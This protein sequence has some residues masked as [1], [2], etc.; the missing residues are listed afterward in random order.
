VQHHL[1]R[2]NASYKYDPVFALGFVSVFDQLMEGYPSEQDKA[3]IFQ[4][5]I[6][7][8]QEEPEKYRKDASQLEAWTSE[9][10]PEKLVAFQDTDGPVESLLKPN[11]RRGR[12]QTASSTT[13]AFSRLAF[14]GLWSWL[15]R[16]T[17]QHWRSY[18]LP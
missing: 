10:S 2:Y 6:Q 3:T 17:L 18:V 12:A 7:A 15:V 9:L 16:Q 4:A 5:Y 1:T 14:L 13:I 11:E 8:L